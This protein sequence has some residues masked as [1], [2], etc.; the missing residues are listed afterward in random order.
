M[1]FSV[2]TIKV[3]VLLSGKNKRHEVYQGALYTEEKQ[4]KQKQ[5]QNPKTTPVYIVVIIMGQHKVTFSPMDNNIHN[6]LQCARMA[7]HIVFLVVKLSCVERSASR[8][9]MARGDRLQRSLS[10]LCARCGFYPNEK[11]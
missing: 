11:V 6:Q 10:V 3:T 9:R 8:G 4:T 5:K 2:C 1:C 7:D